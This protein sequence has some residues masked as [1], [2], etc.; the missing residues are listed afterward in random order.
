MKASQMDIPSKTNKIPNDISVIASSDSVE[1]HLSGSC[2]SKRVRALPSLY[3]DNFEGGRYNSSSRLAASLESR[4]YPNSAEVLPSFPK[5][6][7]RRCGTG[8]WV[9]EITKGV[10]IIYGLFSC[11]L[12]IRRIYTVYTAQESIPF[13]FRGEPISPLE[14]LSAVGLY[15]SVVNSGLGGLVGTDS[16]ETGIFSRPTAGGHNITICAWIEESEISKIPGWSKSW[17]GMLDRRSAAP[18]IMCKG[19]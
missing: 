9:R 12:A 13:K 5:G 18:R 19:V 1:S 6:R 8:G 7:V 14:S 15:E 3:M 10:F 11:L 2:S 4:L 17:G 16:L